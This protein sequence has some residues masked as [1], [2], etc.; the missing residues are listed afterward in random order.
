MM[1]SVKPT[2]DDH[3]AR[4]GATEHM[5]PLSLQRCLWSSR[6]YMKP[7]IVLF[8]LIFCLGLFLL[9]GVGLAITRSNDVLKGISSL[10]ATDEFLEFYDLHIGPKADSVFAAMQAF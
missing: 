2:E 1:S 4:E 5:K 7:V 10:P 3:N 8:A 9:T 6:N